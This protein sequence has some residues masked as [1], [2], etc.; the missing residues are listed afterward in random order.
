M[1]ADVKLKGGTNIPHRT[2]HDVV[3]AHGSSYAIVGCRVWSLRC[4]AIL[5]NLSR[6]VDLGRFSDT[7]HGF[8]SVGRHSNNS[9]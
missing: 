2:R 4:D 1:S 7:R 8:F 9:R 3:L 5:L 6:L